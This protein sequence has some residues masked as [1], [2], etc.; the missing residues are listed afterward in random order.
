MRVGVYMRISEDSESTG[1]GVERQRED[2]ETQAKARRWEVVDHYEDNDLSAFKRSVVRPEF[3][4]MLLDLA[5]GKIDG[6]VIY[7]L[8]R[9]AR[10]PSDLERAIAIYETRP[11]LVFASVQGDINLETPDGKTMARVMVTFA[12]KASM[13]TSRRVARKHLENA[14]N[15]KPVGGHRPFGWKADK[16]QLDPKESVAVRSAVVEI[17][18]GTNLNSIARLWNEGGLL[19]TTGKE[20]THSK[21]RQYLQN[22]RLAGVRTYKGKPMLDAEGHVVMGKWEPMLDRDT[23]DRLQ[24]VLRSPE[25][26]A[27]V[28]RKGARH[29]LLTGILRCGVCN[30]PMYGQKNPSGYAYA[31]HPSSTTTRHTVS[32]S[33]KMADDLVTAL[34]LRIL[35]QESFEK[36]EVK[37]SG[38]AE[39]A[40]TEGQRDELMAAFMAKQLSGAVVFPRVEALELQIAEL[41][42]SRTLWLAETTGPA[43]SSIDHAAWEAMDLDRQRAVI[44]SLL[45]AVLVRPAESK[46]FDPKRLVP[47]KREVRTAPPS[48]KG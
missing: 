12:N 13:D 1:L 3:E 39:L 7:D 19:T 18:A 40:D 10:Q 28:P 35:E 8:D 23:Y 47:V 14:Q 4:R 17:L 46:R 5:M 15:G 20:W 9:F 34:V 48:A 21:V 26:R 33:G 27:R 29:Y 30:G 37:W 16:R 6:I 2:G 31:C 24:I 42:Q 36:P 43:L 44:E 41:K 32:V 25:R 45:S 11:G 38:E 22:E